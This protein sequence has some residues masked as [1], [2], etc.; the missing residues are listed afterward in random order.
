[1]MNLL[2]RFGW[3]YSFQQYVTFRKLSGQPLRL[4]V[5]RTEVR[6]FY[7]APCRFG[8]TLERFSHCWFLVPEITA[9]RP[10]HWTDENRLEGRSVTGSEIGEVEQQWRFEPMLKLSGYL[11]STAQQT[12]SFAAKEVW[13][14]WAMLKGG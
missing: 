14:V 6:H 13:V 5:A 12:S 2:F 11:S 4:F 8:C 7:F 1:M 3:N 9:D 10:L